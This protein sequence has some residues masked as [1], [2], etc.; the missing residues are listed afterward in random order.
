MNQEHIRSERFIHD[1]L[2][3]RAAVAVGRIPEM[4]KEQKRIF[5]I[6]LLWP[7]TQVKAQ[8]GE[9]HTGVVFDLLPEDAELRPAHIKK[10]TA[11]CDAYAVLVVEELPNVVRA[12]FESEHGTET[13]RLPIKD[14]GGVRVLGVAAR[15]S[16]T[17]SIGV[18]WHAN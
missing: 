17:E 18:R 3:T 1:E 16:N 4:W 2:L 11:T 13:W 12:V 9:W 10:V 7:T 14:H 6:I 5:P 8:K 15:S